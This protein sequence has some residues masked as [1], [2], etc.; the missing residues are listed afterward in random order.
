MTASTG[1]EWGVRPPGKHGRARVWHSGLFA[2]TSTL[3]VRRHDDLTW[4]VLFNSESNVHDEAL[5]N[6]IEPLVHQA[7]DSIQD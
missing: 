6:L 3:L 1:C 4:A 2:G 5:S 7:A